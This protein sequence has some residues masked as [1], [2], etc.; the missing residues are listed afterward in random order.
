ADKLAAAR[1]EKERAAEEKRQKAEEARLAKQKAADDAKEQVRLAAEAKKQK[2]EEARQAKLLEKQAAEDQKRRA[3]EEKKLQAEEARLAKLKAKQ[4]AEDRKRQAAAPVVASASVP[5]PSM[6]GPVDVSS[7]RKTVTLVGFRLVDTA[8]RVYIRTDEPV[9]YS[10]SEGADKTVVL[11]L[12]NTRIGQRNNERQL[13]TSFFDTAV[14]MVKPDVGE[15]Q[16]VRVEIKLKES[17]PYQ[18]KQEGNEVYVE[19]QRPAR[20]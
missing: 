9:R 6:T 19:F 13:D 11:L 15:A 4:D 10:L 14:A 20:H 8:S 16:S 12:E 7:R 2:A 18:A 3:A 1:S 17:V 5:A